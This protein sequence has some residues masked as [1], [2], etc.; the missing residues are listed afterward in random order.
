MKKNK[1]VLI[2]SRFVK[3]YEP[4]RLKE[5]SVRAGYKADIVKYGQ[6]KIEVVS[7]MGVRIDLRRGRKLSD[8]DLV[9]M[10][11]ASKSGS[12][13]VAVK[14]VILSELARLKINVINGKSFEKWPLLGKIEQGVEMARAQ[15][16]TIEFVS[17]GSRLGWRLYPGSDPG[18]E[19]PVIVKGRFGSHG[20][21]VNL[22]N[23]KESL[24]KLVRN[25]K[26]GNVLIQKV[27][28]VRQ[29]YRCIVLGGEYLGEM[30]HRQKLRYGG[31]GKDEYTLIKF[32]WG[33]MDRLRE[34]CLRAAEL[35]ECD[36]C[37]I[38][39]GWDEQRGDWVVFEV[40]RTAQFKYFEKRTGIGVAER[41]V[42]LF[43]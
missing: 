16:S 41:M 8:Y 5:E 19:P 20:K 34:I 42:R 4:V 33:K 3:E 25:Y 28:P 32:G 7:K 11:A 21:T 27:L 1:R 35:F 2:L 30:R 39:V 14:Q 13:M 23:D 10:R 29:W 9:V 26:A 18:Y 36:Y 12:S 43:G 24:E 22:I 38:D 37:G 17:F 15:I 40:N 31:A 6:V